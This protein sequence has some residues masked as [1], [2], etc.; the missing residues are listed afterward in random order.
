MVAY[1]FIIFLLLFINRSSHGM[2]ALNGCAYVAGGQASG[3]AALAGG[4]AGP[5]SSQLSLEGSWP[6]MGSSPPGTAEAVATCAQ[7]LV[8][9]MPG[10][11]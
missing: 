1:L 5:S 11:G 3:A 2:A 9:G 8:K 7:L 6:P 10:C 4:A